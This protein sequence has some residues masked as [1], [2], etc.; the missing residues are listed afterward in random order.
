MKLMTLQ[1]KSVANILKNN[2][3]YYANYSEINFP[4]YIKQ[5]K[6][7]AEYCGFSHCPIFCAIEGDYEIISNSN[8]KKSDDNI[9]IHLDVPDRYC[10][11]MEYYDFSTWL[12]YSEGQEYDSYYKWGK[13]KALENPDKY[14][15]LYKPNKVNSLDVP[16]I[17]IQE[18][19]PEWVIG[20]LNE[21][22]LT[23][24]TRLQLLNQSKEASTTKSYGTTRYD[25]RNLQHIYNSV[26]AFN[27]IDQNALFKANM[28]SFFIPVQGET[29]N[30]EVEV[31]FD[32]ILDS[33]NRELKN[34]DYNLE[35][36]VIY[37]AIIDAINKQ[38]IFVSCSCPDFKYRMA[39]WASK[40]RFN[41]GQPQVIPARITNP[42]NSQGAGCKHIMKVLADLDWAMK[43]ASCINN[44]IIYMQEHYPD[45]YENVIFPALYDM[46]YVRAIDQGIIQVEDEIEELPDDEE[47]EVVIQDEDEQEVSEEE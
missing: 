40:G 12:Y 20:K 44:Y 23:E 19:R 37:R 41:S 45:K 27:K 13:K 47:D 1:S 26:A 35:Y 16:Q 39:Y 18:I 43:L 28:L 31:L 4:D 22:L 25:R 5:W 36:K 32:G 2:K 15:K 9:L 6:K 33:I 30:Y 24:K 14:F 34:N 10:K 7:L 17:C 3:V 21:N 29:D 46:S 42:N 8:L 38:D 11:V